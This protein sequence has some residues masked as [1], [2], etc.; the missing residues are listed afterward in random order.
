MVGTSIWKIWKINNGCKWLEMAGNGWK[1]LEIAGIGW[2]CGLFFEKRHG[3]NS[4]SQLNFLSCSLSFHH[5][6]SVYI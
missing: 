1:L 4:T 6:G 2:K 3:I 5:N